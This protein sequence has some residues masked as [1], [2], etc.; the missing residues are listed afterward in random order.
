ME[1]RRLHSKHELKIVEDYSNKRTKSAHIVCF[2]VFPSQSARGRAGCVNAG[3]RCYLRRCFGGVP[4]ALSEELGNSHHRP[5]RLARVLISVNCPV[6][7][8]LVVQVTMK[9]GY[10]F[11]SVCHY[12]I[13][14]TILSGSST[15]SVEYSVL[16]VQCSW[17]LSA[18]MEPKNTKETKKRTK[19]P[20]SFDSQ[21]SLGKCVRK[22]QMCQSQQMLLF[23]K[24]L[25]RR[26]V[27]FV[28]RIG[29]FSP[30]QTQ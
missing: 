27:C 20:T 29:E 11:S 26:S 7:F 13:M 5:S 21:F 1:E 8:F 24:M 30:P 19:V 12:W 4:F 10:Q 2:S 15:S 23:V 28:W 16:S 14:F 18:W 22:S 3:R 25:W 9:I 17:A 6:L